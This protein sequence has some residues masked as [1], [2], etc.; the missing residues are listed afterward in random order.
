MSVKIKIIFIFEWFFGLQLAR[1]E[2]VTGYRIDG[3]AV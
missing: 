3:Y 2:K 1:M